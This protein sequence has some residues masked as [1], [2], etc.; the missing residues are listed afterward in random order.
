MGDPQVLL[1]NSE[2]GQWYAGPD[3]WIG[4]CSG[5]REFGT[6]EEAIRFWRGLGVDGMEVVLH[7]DD[8]QCNLV[9]PL[10]EQ[11]R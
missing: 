8:P 11:G 1:R 6:V 3:R 5:A 10:R 4:A 2:T 7:Y 9:L